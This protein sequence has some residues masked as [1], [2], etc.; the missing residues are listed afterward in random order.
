[1]YNES[2]GVIGGFGGYATLEFYKN[3]L[4]TFA[5]ENEREFP[6]IIMDCNFTMP[7]RTRA[8]LYDECYEDIVNSICES[9]ERLIAYGVKYIIF[10]CGTAHYFL[11]DVVKRIPEASELIINIINVTGEQMSLCGDESAFII[12]AEGALKKQLYET[13]FNKLKIE[14]ISPD[15]NE[16]NKI[17]Y[18]IEIVKRNKL[19]FRVID[20]FIEFIDN[21]N[22]TNIV[23]GCTEFSLLLDYCFAN[24]DCIQKEKLMGFKF[25]DPMKLVLEKV[26]LMIK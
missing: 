2:I 11:N 3:F 8:L 12:A 10:V 19:E 1:M 17:R 25:Y 16:Y 4:I 5:N 22:T 20:E 26:K 21:R 23:L 13:S 15:V 14:C 6:H 7:S 18:F 24:F 9:V